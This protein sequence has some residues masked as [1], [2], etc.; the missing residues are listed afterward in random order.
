MEANYIKFNQ[1]PQVEEVLPGNLLII[2][3][4][5]GTK[6]V[7]FK[8]FVI[9]PTNTSFYNALVTNIRSISTFSMS[10]S[11]TINK[12]TD[13]TLDAVDTRFLQLT[14][15]LIA[16]NPFWYRY[17]FS[18]TLEVG[19]RMKT[20][21]FISPIPDIALVDCTA[22]IIKHDAVVPYKQ[23]IYNLQRSATTAEGTSDL[24]TYTFTCC[25]SLAAGDAETHRVRVLKGY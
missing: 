6:I 10:L 20:T 8:D 5:T 24:Y 15:N 16:I 23:Y 13:Q 25:A 11:T 17:F 3:D 2:E 22:M 18:I 4:Q 9:G 19:Q 14:S 7:D 12:N 1:L 21:N